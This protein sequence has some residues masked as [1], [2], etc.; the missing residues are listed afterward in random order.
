MS[1]T[2][3]NNAVASNWDRESV[4]TKLKEMQTKS[5]FNEKYKPLV[6]LSSDPFHFPIIQDDVCITPQVD[7][8]V[9]SATTNLV[10]PTHISD[11]DFAT[12]NIGLFL[13]LCTPQPFLSNSVISSSFS[14]KLDSL[15]ARLCGKIMAMKSFFID[16]LQTIKN[17]SL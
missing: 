16:R 3:L 5:I 6:T 14:L 12:L 17:K 9:I 1:L 11:P 2:Y 8:D 4:E 7:R 15:E 13:T 10:I